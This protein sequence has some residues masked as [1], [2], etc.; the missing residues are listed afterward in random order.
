MTLNL[1]LLYFVW[2][3]EYCQTSPNKNKSPNLWHVTSILVCCIFELPHSNRPHVILKIIFLEYFFVF[4][5]LKLWNKFCQDPKLC[6]VLN[7]S[8]LFNFSN[9]PLFVKKHLS[10]VELARLCVQ[11]KS[12]HLLVL[13]KNFRKIKKRKH[14]RIIF[15]LGWILFWSRILILTHQRFHEILRKVGT[16]EVATAWNFCH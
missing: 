5:A 16:V 15:I 6:T 2:T 14:L 10:L 12:H 11:K 1:P 9:F 13:K 7:V 8:C 4:I 3:E